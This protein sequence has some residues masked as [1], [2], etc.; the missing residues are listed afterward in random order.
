[1]A[2]LRELISRSERLNLNIPE[3]PGK[4]R[5][6]ATVTVKENSLKMYVNTS[7]LICVLI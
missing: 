7:N 6:K 1:M 4:C 2:H 5:V 3:I